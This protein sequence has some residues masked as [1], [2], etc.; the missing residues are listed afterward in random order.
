MHGHKK[1][2]G[3]PQRVR[4]ALLGCMVSVCRDYLISSIAFITKLTLMLST[5]ASISA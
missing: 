2:E 1:K 4:G 5:R 3:I